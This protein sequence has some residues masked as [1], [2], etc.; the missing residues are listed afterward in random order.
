MKELNKRLNVYG[1]E[2]CGAAWCE[3]TYDIYNINDE[4]C[5]PEFADCTLQEVKEF[6]EELES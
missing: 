2:I 1:Y 6:L 3:G 5:I 4:S